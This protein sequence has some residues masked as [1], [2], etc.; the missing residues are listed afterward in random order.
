MTQVWHG[1][2]VNLLV[3]PGEQGYDPF[4]VM[5]GDEN[6]KVKGKRREVKKEKRE[7]LQ[8]AAVEWGPLVLH[9]GQVSGEVP[10]SFIPNGLTVT[11]SV[12]G[13]ASPFSPASEHPKSS[14]SST[15]V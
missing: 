2:Y 7:V 13:I 6:E 10:Q 12:Q 9:S 14:H 5:A 8:M 3:G 15:F 4:I 11:S 1:K